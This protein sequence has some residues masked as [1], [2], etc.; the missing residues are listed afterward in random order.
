MRPQLISASWRLIAV[1][2]NFFS[3]YQSVKWRVIS[4]VQTIP[5]NSLVLSSASSLSNVVGHTVDIN[6]PDLT[7]IDI[8]TTLHGQMGLHPATRD[9]HVEGLNWTQRNVAPKI[10]YRRARHYRIRW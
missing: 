6:R 8:G 7:F 9:Y 3:D 10:R 1:P 4:E 2:D 5:E